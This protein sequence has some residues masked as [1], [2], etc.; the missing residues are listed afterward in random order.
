M[1]RGMV[2]KADHFSQFSANGGLSFNLQGAPNFRGTDGFGS[3]GTA[4]PD[5]SGISTI[6]ALLD[7]APPRRGSISEDL[8]S[9]NL[10]SRVCHWFSAREEPLVYINGKPFVLRDAAEPLR[11]LYTYRGINTIR[12]ESLE[13]RLVEDV[14]REAKKWSG[15]IL[16]HDED[17]HGKVV[18]SWIA[19]DSIQTPR[20]VFDAFAA[21]GY[22]LKYYRAPISPEQGP[23]DMYLDQYVDV[24]AGS[25]TPNDPLVFNCGVGIG[26]TTFAMIVAML[27]RRVQLINSG[28][29]DPFPVYASMDAQVSEAMLLRPV[30]PSLLS[31]GSP[32][33]RWAPPPTSAIAGELQNMHEQQVQNRALLRCIYVLERG[34]SGQG[35]GRSAIEW[36][37]ARGN[38]I[39]DL[40]NAI[41]GNYQIILQLTSVLPG[42]LA[43]KRLLD[44]MIDRN[45]V[46]INLREVILEHRIRYSVKGDAADLDKALGTLERYFFLLAFAGYVEEQ[47]SLGFSVKFSDWIK[48]R[49]EIWSMIQS[50]RKRGANRLHMF[51]PVHDLSLLASSPVIGGVYAASEMPVGMELESF[52]VKNRQGSVLTSQTILKIDFW[53]KQSTDEDAANFR[54]IPGMFVYGVAQPTVRGMKSVVNSVLSEPDGPSK[55]IWICL[56]EEPIV[57]VNSVPYVLRDHY[58][59]L[60]NLKS[61]M[62]ITPSRLEMME[63]RLCS[64]ICAELDQ[65]DGKLLLHTETDG[66]ISP[67]W[68]QALPSAIQTLRQVVLQ[69]KKEN[70]ELDYYR[71]PVTAEHAPQEEDFDFLMR[72]LSS[73][74][75]SDTAVIMNCQIGSGRSTTGTVVA[76][77]IFHWSNSTR[78]VGEDVDRSYGVIHSLLRTIRN[79]L[80]AK[81]AVDNAIDACDKTINLRESIE[82]WRIQAENESDP[83]A[84]KRA[85]R[86]SQLHLERYFMLICFQAYLDAHPVDESELP[87]FASWVEDHQEFATMRAEIEHGDM[88]TLTPVDKLNP[89]DGVAL[90]SEEL[91]VVK[92]RRGQVLAPQ[93]ILKADLFPNCQKLALLERVDGAP[94]YRRV[95]MMQ[96]RHQAPEVAK[97]AKFPSSS[98]VEKGMKV[99]A[100]TSGAPMSVR[101]QTTGALPDLSSSFHASLNWEN[102]DAFTYGVA[103]PTRDGLA[104]VLRRCGAGPNGKRHVL[105]TSLRE[106]PVLYVLGRPF[107]LRLFQDPLKNLEATGITRERVE[108]M[109]MYVV[110]IED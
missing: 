78:P 102:G 43:T 63:E 76:S 74:D 108:M 44:E 32:S 97:G 51:R 98:V 36:V 95:A 110:C 91:E 66:H 15:L 82:T 80:E 27:L 28:S 54:K 57:M 84:R 89:G 92:T 10:S 58:F 6:L 9:L 70:C 42:G 34:L 49:S 24:L 41:L 33:K 37:L 46:M 1:S 106:E 75:W 86:R 83:A 101:R 12:L 64:D 48:S 85:T 23:E 79:G 68:E 55:V 13:E 99:D 31:S 100:V 4:Q 73:V 53:G 7:C 11:N 30:S 62:G 25:A 45:D 2:L 60:R 103:M 18:P 19:L 38:M 93:T 29:P 88:S 8:G 107:V 96:A 90:T 77:L 26:R 71:I 81:R 22:P 72:V 17:S 35:G 50:L 40:K 20:Q 52:V 109:E 39:D 94:N 56:R 5:K 69:L 59:T 65:Y 61:F 87:S 3:F 16:V 67:M 47:G 14:V 104:R 21:S 105:W